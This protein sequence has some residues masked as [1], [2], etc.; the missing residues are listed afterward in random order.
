MFTRPDNNV[1][2]STIL[3]SDIDI[4]ELAARLGTDRLRRNGRVVFYDNF[5]DGLAWSMPTVPSILTQ[6]GSI[7]PYTPPGIMAIT[8]TTI[9]PISAYLSLPIIS[10]PK[11]GYEITFHIDDRHLPNLV[12]TI[13]FG[14]E[15]NGLNFI[16]RYDLSFPKWQ[17]WRGSWGD[18]AG[19][20]APINFNAW[21]NIKFSVNFDNALYMKFYYNRYIFDISYGI[22]PAS[23]QDNL[24]FSITATDA[25]ANA[26]ILVDNVIITT[27][28]A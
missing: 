25:G 12:D 6:A 22:P 26:G 4:A 14:I 10:T 17:L 18:I 23:A 28:E 21:H 3:S 15:G 9:N 11:V 16:L 19:V 5:I 7:K 24:I 1:K 2:P 20:I 8:P 13:D 27:D